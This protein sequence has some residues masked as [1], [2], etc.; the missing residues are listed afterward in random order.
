VTLGRLAAAQRARPNLVL[1]PLGAAHPA[2]V[3]TFLGSLRDDGGSSQTLGSRAA[4]IRFF[5]RETGLA[6]P[7]DHRVVRDLLEGARREDAGRDHCR[8]TVTAKRLAT[9]LEI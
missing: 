1:E 3:A 2:L 9:A 7:T 8:A 6:S 5:H 4:A